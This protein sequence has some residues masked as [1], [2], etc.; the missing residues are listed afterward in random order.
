MQRGRA[1]AGIDQHVAA[2]D[3]KLYLA[4]WGDQTEA[5]GGGGGGGGGSTREELVTNSGRGAYRTDPNSL[6]C[7]ATCNAGAMLVWDILLK[8][9]TLQKPS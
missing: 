5:T 9:V 2:G 4:R 3:G 6:S 1:K 8:L 7:D